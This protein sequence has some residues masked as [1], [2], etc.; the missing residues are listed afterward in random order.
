M[1]QDLQLLAERHAADPSPSNRE[2][3]VIAAVPLVRSL[4]GRLSLPDHML[5]S[6]EDLENVGLLGLL[7]ALDGY[8]PT[9][10]T[11]FV[12]YAYGRIRGAIVD[13]LRSIDALPRERRKQLA[14]AQQAIETLRQKI[15]DEP[16]DQDVA[17]FL[18]LSIA[19]YHAILTDAQRRF[20]LSLHDSAGPDGEQ[21][22]LETIP[23]ED[24]FAAFDDIDRE[25]LY[26]YIE[27]MVRELPQR[28]QTILALY[29]FENLTLREIAQ[30]LN[31]TEARISQILGKILSGLRNRLNKSRVLTT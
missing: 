4:I 18:G 10:G 23:N 5:A 22:V 1:A 15:G 13:Y 11:P 16:Q 2:A 19:E 14:E 12:S 21:S 25:S 8:D 17:D 31:L 30:L 28:E 27:T 7:Q 6:R 20:A 9:R 24:A 3:V 29:Y 26:T